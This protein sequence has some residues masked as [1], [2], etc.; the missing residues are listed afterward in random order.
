MDLYFLSLPDDI[1]QIISYMKMKIER[2]EWEPVLDELKKHKY[3]TYECRVPVSNRPFRHYQDILRVNE[4]NGRV[5]K[6][7]IT[8]SPIIRGMK[9]GWCHGHDINPLRCINCRET[10]CKSPNK[11]IVTDVWEI[12][13]FCCGGTGHHVSNCEMF[14]KYGYEG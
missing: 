6:Y 7:Y 13:C 8:T 2:K 11:C 12:N 3:K 5:T 14:I 9:Q 1:C 4:F 10:S